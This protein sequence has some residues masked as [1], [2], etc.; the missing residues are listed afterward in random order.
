MTKHDNLSVRQSLSF[1]FSP[2]DLLSQ[3]A[4]SPSFSFKSDTIDVAESLA[5]PGRNYQPE[6]AALHIFEAEV[7]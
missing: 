6:H 4:V 3:D 5:E 7:R 1:Q 2:Q